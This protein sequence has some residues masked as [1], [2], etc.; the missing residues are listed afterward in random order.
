L[1]K[2]PGVRPIGF[3][4]T[5]RHIIAKAVLSV[6]KSDVQDAAGSIQLCAGQ[7]AGAESAV[8]AVRDLFQQDGT[9]AVLLVDASNAFNS[10][11]HNTA[12]HNIEFE[13]PDISIFLINTYGAAPE[14][15]K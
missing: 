3:G 9:E 2:N 10:L 15:A 11:N 13:C 14:T 6:T 5:S 12:L 1:D 8:H 4:E 7:I